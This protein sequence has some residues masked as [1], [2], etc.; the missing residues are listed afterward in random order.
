MI[1]NY[2]AWGTLVRKWA[3][4]DD[5]EYPLP[6]DLSDVK[7]QCIKIAAAM[8][9]I[10]AEPAPRWEAVIK[11]PDTMS[12]LAILQNSR[13]VLAIRLPAKKAVEEVIARLSDP[14]NIAEPYPLPA[15]YAEQF[16]QAPLRFRDADEKKKFL[17]KRIGDYSV[18]N[19]A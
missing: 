2:E 15:F 4:G 5:P 1:E 7:A 14:Q 11:F 19:C 18:S 13:E 6:R 9:L 8:D 17:T 16:G 10:V 12:G 3:F